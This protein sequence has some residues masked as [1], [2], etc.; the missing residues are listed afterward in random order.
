MRRG[1][2]LYARPRRGRRILAAVVAA[3]AGVAIVTLGAIKLVPQLLGS[4]GSSERPS[5]TAS[6]GPR[7]ASARAAGGARLGSVAWVRDGALRLLDLDTCTVRTLVQQGATPPVRFSHDG[8][9][10]AFGRGSIVSAAG[11]EVRNP[12]GDLSS[13]QWSPRSDLLAGITENGGVVLGGPER[14]ARTLLPDATHAGHLAFSP[15]GRSLAIDAGGDSV[16]VVDVAS[17]SATTIYRVTPGTTAPPEV[18]EWSPDGRWVLF[19]SR[20]PGKAAVP[21]NAA[22][23][24]GGPW[25]N[26]FD[27]VLPYGDF[28][29]WCGDALVLSGGGTRFPSEGNQILTSAPPR[30][31]FRNLSVDFSRSWIWPACSPSG[32]WI[33]STVTPNVR[34]SPPGKGARSLWLLA[35]D[36]TRRVRLT[37]ATNAAYEL[38]RWSANGRFLLV[39]RRSALPSSSGVLLLIP[40]DPSSGKAG[41]PVGPIATIGPAPGTSGHGDWSS[42]TDWYRPG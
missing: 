23:A 35:A 14:A 3:I 26:V 37:A 39:V 25:V 21:L 8:R 1:R 30:W 41:K 15:N 22:P 10:I 29:S 12:L 17:G 9:W 7:C 27:P 34:E 36:G 31:R 11:G 5:G 6:P 20:F 13:W 33:A 42:T 32:R 18:T 16:E 24:A 19:F 40:V 4:G 2:H 38:P 28:L